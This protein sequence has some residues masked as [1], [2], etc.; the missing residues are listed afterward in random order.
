MSGVAVS[1]KKKA[2]IQVYVRCLESRRFLSR[3]PQR[4]ARRPPPRPRHDAPAG[5]RD[6]TRPRRD[7]KSVVQGKSVDV[8]GRRIIKKKSRHTS[9]RTL[10]G[11]QTFPLPPPAPPGAPPA[12][13]TTP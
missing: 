10:P 1:L 9:L 11:V 13:T 7:R 3:P 2:G 5:R 4:P 8:G 6:R 12:A